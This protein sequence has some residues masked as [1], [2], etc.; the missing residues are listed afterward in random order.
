MEDAVDLEQG[1]K[2]LHPHTQGTS[3]R[4]GEGADEGPPLLH[5]GE[6]V[7]HDMDALEDDDEHDAHDDD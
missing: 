5:G 3:G 7:Q 6:G 2:G 1:W 4:R